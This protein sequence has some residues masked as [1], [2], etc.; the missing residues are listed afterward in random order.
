MKT[1]LITGASR[2]IGHAIARKYISEEYSVILVCKGEVS[3]MD[4]LVQAAADK[5]SVCLCYRC[6]VSSYEEVR[7]LCH[8]LQEK[9][10]SVD[11]LINNAGISRIGL[12]QD[13]SPEEWDHILSTNLSSAFYLCRELI[14]QMLKR[15][16]GKILNISSVWGICGAACEAAYSASKGGLNAFTKALAKELAPSNIQVNAIACGAIDT[17]MNQHLSKEERQAL[18][19]EIPSGSL[20]SPEEI[21]D[22]AFALTQS[23]SYLTGEIIKIDGGWI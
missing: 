5:G 15:H 13:M 20:G 22:F 19:A 2:G 17:Q 21:A 3:R 7:T 4:D 23:G 1:V 12:I 9:H 14:P 6:D 18:C 8:N 10:I 16:Q 11:I